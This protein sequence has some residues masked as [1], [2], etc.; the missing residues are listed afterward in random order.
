MGP[1][2]NV[3]RGLPLFCDVTVLTPLT[4]VGGAR[5]GTSNRGGAL[6]EQAQRS[7]DGNDSIFVFTN[8]NG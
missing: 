7:N 1:G 3:A 8:K 6:L 2:L 4:T 5:P